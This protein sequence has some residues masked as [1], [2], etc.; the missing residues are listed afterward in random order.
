V[1]C[2]FFWGYGGGGEHTCTHMYTYILSHVYVIHTSIFTTHLL[3]RV[4][5]LELGAPVG[6]AAHAEGGRLPLHV[7]TVA[8][9]LILC[10]WWVGAGQVRRTHTFTY[11]HTD[12]FYIYIYTHIFCV[13][14]PGG[15][16]GVEAHVV[17]LAVLG[18]GAG[19]DHAVG[20]LG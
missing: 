18:V 9:V 16:D 13:Y 12:N 10:W 7:V 6:G 20:L 8:V 17:G 15:G 14:L 3:G 5:G 2:E 4:L 1:G 19:G 11:T